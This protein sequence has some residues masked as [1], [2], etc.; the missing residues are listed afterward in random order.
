MRPLKYAWFHLGAKSKFTKALEM[1]AMYVEPVNLYMVGSLEILKNRFY[2]SGGFQVPL[3]P[4][5]VESDSAAYAQAFDEV[6]NYY[7]VFREQNILNLNSLNAGAYFLQPL[8]PWLFKLGVSFNKPS[9]YELYQGVKN[10]YAAFLNYNLEVTWRRQSVMHLLQS[11]ISAFQGEK[12]RSRKDWESHVEGSLFQFRYGL[13][14]HSGSTGWETA[15][16]G[17]FKSPDKNRPNSF[18]DKMVQDEENNNIQR[19]YLDLNWVKATRKQALVSMSFT[20]TVLYQMLDNLVGFQA[21]AE[22][23]YKFKMK[24]NLF[25]KTS[26]SVLYG[27]FDET[28]FMGGGFKLSFTQHRNRKV[29]PPLYPER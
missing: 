6:F 12:D 10:F 17:A 19:C 18:Q 2:A 29:L 21:E 25:V 13:R 27:N 7:N 24:K 28:Q 23:K 14:F 20:P 3:Q 16:G 9:S 5:V 26:V 8:G 4:A 15:L 1:P 11:K 22:G